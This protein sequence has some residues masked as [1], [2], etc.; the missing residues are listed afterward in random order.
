[1]RDCE[2]VEV[3]VD[4]DVEMAVVVA[5]LVVV[6]AEVVVYRPNPTAA[7]IMRVAAVAANIMVETAPL[8]SVFIGTP[9]ARVLYLGE[10]RLYTQIRPTSSGVP[11]A[12]SRLKNQM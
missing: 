1:M 2:I 7:S 10:F 11:R 3:S 5:V 8:D 12:L 6:L 9:L 4:V